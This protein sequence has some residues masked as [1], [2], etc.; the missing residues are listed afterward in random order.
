MAV[1]IGSLR[2]EQELQLPAGRGDQEGRKEAGDVELGVEAVRWSEISSGE[3]TR[4]SVF[5]TNTTNLVG[6]IGS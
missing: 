5:P 3:K 2:G 4:R 6:V 1:L